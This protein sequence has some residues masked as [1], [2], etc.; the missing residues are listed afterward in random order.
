[1]GS[2]VIADG[3]NPAGTGTPPF[4]GTRVPLALEKANTYPAPLVVSLAATNTFEVEAAIA[5]GVM[6][7]VGLA[8]S[9]RGGCERGI[10]PVG[11]SQV[12]ARSE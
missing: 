3:C 6:T 10:Q 4:K 7:S 8:G 9:V 2:R 5:V 12:G 1:M 11:T